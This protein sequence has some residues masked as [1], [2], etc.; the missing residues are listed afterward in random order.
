L[1]RELFVE[2][3]AVRGFRNLKEVDLAL[4]PGFIVVSGDNGQGKTNLLEAVYALATS[5]SFR[6][7]KPGE[8][9]RYGDE[10]A[11]VRAT[12]AFGGERREQSLGLKEGGR[13]AK[14]DGQRPPSLT[15]YAVRTPAVVFHPG[16]VALSMGGGGERRKLLDRTSL[17]LA[18]APSD[19]LDRYSLALRE[20]QKALELR[21]PSATDAASWE[22]LMVRHGREVH[23]ARDQAAGKLAEAA[24]EAFLRIAARGVTFDVAYSPGS[25]GD[26][27][28]FREMLAK[29]RARDARRG[30]A[31]VGPHRDDLSLM[32]DGH[33]ARGFASQGQ[34]RTV[35]LAL[36]AAEVEVIAAARD[37]RPLL[38]LDDVSSEL[39]RART[40]A[41]FAALRDEPGQVLLTTTRPDLIETGVLCRV[42]DR[43]DF[44]VVAGRVE[45]S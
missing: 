44:T 2:T 29:S 32:I 15:A 30:T 22:E 1:V 7:N 21:G 37:L 25:P 23:A 8:L 38:L 9:V 35:V 36:K 28:E 11:S 31:S 14:I 39:D 6:V 4:G 33:P 24:R 3:L 5:K 13:Y 26:P 17:Y 43:R 42:E 40:A 41:L 16:E 27:D 18:P 34:H 20:R 12:V 19:D 45:A 10:V